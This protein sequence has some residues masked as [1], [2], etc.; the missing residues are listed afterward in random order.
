[1]S[2]HLEEQE[3]SVHQINYN[4]IDQSLINS[5][6]TQNLIPTLMKKDQMNPNSQSMKLSL[7]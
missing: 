6:L 1:M 7:S 4:E 5:E 3:T 2:K